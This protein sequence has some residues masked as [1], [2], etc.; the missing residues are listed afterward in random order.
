MAVWMI[1]NDPK[2]CVCVCWVGFAWLHALWS[3]EFHIF[4]NLKKPRCTLQQC[5]YRRNNY[6]QNKVAVVTGT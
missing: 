4:P 5:S 3:E 2:L 1:S 6:F